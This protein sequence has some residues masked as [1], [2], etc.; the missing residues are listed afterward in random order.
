MPQSDSIID[1]WQSNAH[2]WIESI[3]QHL[4]ESR[5]LITNQAIIEAI[6]KYKTS[7]VLDLG[8]GEGWLTRALNAKKIH[9]V[10]I[11]GVPALIKNAQTKGEEEYAVIS[12]NEIIAG[13]SLPQ[14]PFEAIVINFGLFMEDEVADLLI[15]LKRHLLPEGKIFIQTLHPFFKISQEKPYLSSWEEN[16]WAG[17]GEHYTK[18][19]QWFSRTLAGWMRL[20]VD[21][22]YII[23]ELQ[24]PLNPITQKPQSMIFCLKL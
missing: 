23:Q 3:D 22:G 15:S 20:F 24:E 13:K 4:I 6:L 14:S 10:G 16:G 19:F 11:D 9:T 12:Y 21:A 17:L 7:K 5:K 8:C 1:S 2:H 18:P